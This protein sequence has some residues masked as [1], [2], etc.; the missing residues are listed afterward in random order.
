VR[1]LSSPGISFEG[2]VAIRQGAD[3]TCVVTSGHYAFCWGINYEG[4]FGDGT[5]TNSLVPVQVTAL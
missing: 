1:V 2:V 4:A 5:K 3:H